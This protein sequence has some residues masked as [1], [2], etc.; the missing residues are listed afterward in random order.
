MRGERGTREWRAGDKWQKEST[1]VGGGE[2][3]KKRKLKRRRVTMS[4]RSIR[5]ALRL[6]ATLA[7]PAAGH[8]GHSWIHTCSSVRRIYQWPPPKKEEVIYHGGHKSACLT[9]PAHSSRPDLFTL[10]PWLSIMWQLSDATAADTRMIH[11]WTALC[12][13]QPG[14]NLESST[15]NMRSNTKV[16]DFMLNT[17]LSAG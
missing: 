11:G 13:A 1:Q 16:H 15:P 17:R 2:G 5:L 6:Q 10:P 8:R 12:S 14:K 4:G 3:G 9:S 7:A